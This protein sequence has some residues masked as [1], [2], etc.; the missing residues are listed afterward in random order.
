MSWPATRCRHQGHLIDGAHH[1]VDSEM[2]FKIADVVP[3]AFKEGAKKAR[4]SLLE[5]VMVVEVRTPE[6]Y[7]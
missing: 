1:E 7:I 2:A 3:L 5:P 4:W 6:E